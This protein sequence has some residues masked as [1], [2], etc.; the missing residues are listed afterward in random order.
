MAKP[1]A[2]LAA[3]AK[4]VA[5]LDDWRLASLSLAARAAGSLAIGLALVEGRLGAAEALVALHL[6]ALP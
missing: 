1:E 6:T 4:A 5:A 3:V 2:S